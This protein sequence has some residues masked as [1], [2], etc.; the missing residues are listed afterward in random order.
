[1][2]SRVAIARSI[3]VARRMTA[4]LFGEAS[5]FAT[6]NQDHAE[7]LSLLRQA[8]T[9]QDIEE[10]RLELMPR[11]YEELVTHARAE[12]RTVYAEMM[13]REHAVASAWV[14]ADEHA[15]LEECLRQVLRSGTGAYKER[16]LRLLAALESHIEDEETRGFS[17]AEK[18]L[19][20]EQMQRLED[21][22][23]R[24]KDW[25]RQLLECGVGPLSLE[26]PACVCTPLDLVGED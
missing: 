15:D 22:Y 8:V 11:I 24:E 1:M 19:A 7:L 17:L 10:A 6:L 9:A 25:Q 20:A 4:V 21:A 18:V 3:G 5:L 12:E 26:T 16:A 14:S 2:A 13:Q 23:L